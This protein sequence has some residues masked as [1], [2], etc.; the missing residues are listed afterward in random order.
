MDGI[1]HQL[2]TSQVLLHNVIAGSR[3]L[4]ALKDIIMKTKSELL[5]E[6]TS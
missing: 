6:T 2:G 5:E 3:D 4:D 1:Y